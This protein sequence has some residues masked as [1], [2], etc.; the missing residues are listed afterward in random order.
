MPISQITDLA[1]GLTTIVNLDDGGL[2][3]AEDAAWA[4]DLIERLKTAI[5]AEARRRILDLVPEWQQ[6]NLNARANALNDKRLSG[7]TLSADE[8]AERAAMKMLWEAINAIRTKS[9][10]IEASLS[11][12]DRAGLESFNP[13]D[14]ACW[15]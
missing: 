8:E 9:D 5:K 3:A 7:D 6:A 14:Q 2:R 1:T 15:T 13:R 12:L 11:A 10:E 4:D